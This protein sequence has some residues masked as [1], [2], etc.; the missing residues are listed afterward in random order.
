MNL[1]K[2]ITAVIFI[3]AIVLGYYLYEGI[4]STIEKAKEIE[5]VENTVKA[6]LELIRDAQVAYQGAY[7]DYADTW[8]KL[9]SFVDS[10]KIWLIQRTEKITQLSYGAEK[11]EFIYD[12]LGFRTVRDSLFNIPN[13]DPTSLPRLPHSPDKFFSLYAKD[14]IRSGVSVDYIEV[15]DTYPF[16]RSRTEDNEIENRR[17]LKFGSRTEITLA[18]NWQ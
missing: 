7:G 10:G 2:I 14:S 16:D 3:G 18:G 6:K 4:N 12:T 13:F 11:S 15:V 5:R 8:E 17:P 9:I 1:T